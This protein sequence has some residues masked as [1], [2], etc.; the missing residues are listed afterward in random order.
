MHFATLIRDL[1]AEGKTLEVSV[2]TAW[3]MESQEVFANDEAAML[4]YVRAYLR[5]FR[6]AVPSPTAMKFEW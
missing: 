5:R 1:N 6:A 3:F 2:I 4:V